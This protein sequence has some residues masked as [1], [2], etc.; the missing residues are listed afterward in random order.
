MKRNDSCLLSK[1]WT[2]LLTNG[3]QPHHW[4]GLR[5]R[6]RARMGSDYEVL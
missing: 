5:S 1:N 2:Y 4:E 3:L 6:N